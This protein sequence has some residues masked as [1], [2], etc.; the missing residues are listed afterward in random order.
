MFDDYHH[1]QARKERDVVEAALSRLRLVAPR[2]VTFSDD[3]VVAVDA[4]GGEHRLTRGGLDAPVPLDVVREALWA[5]GT[6]SFSRSRDEDSERDLAGQGTWLVD[7]LP[8][9]PVTLKPKKPDPT[10]LEQVFSADPDDLSLLRSAYRLSGLRVDVR[11]EG[12]TRARDVAVAMAAERA[13]LGLPTTLALPPARD[14]YGRLQE[15]APADGAGTWDG[16]AAGEGWSVLHRDPHSGYPYREREPETDDTVVV[17]SDRQA[18]YYASRLKEA[19]GSVPGEVALVRVFL[20]KSR[21]VA[22]IAFSPALLARLS[23]DHGFV[24]APWDVHARR[25]AKAGARVRPPNTWHPTTEAVAEAFV[26]RRAPRGMV[27]GN[28]LFFHGPVAYSRYRSSPVAAFA[29]AKDGSQVILTGREPNMRGD[30]VVSMALSD[31]HAA[32]G[33]RFAILPLEC[34]SGLVTVGDV[35]VRHFADKAG[36]SKKEGDYPATCTV[37]PAG[38]AAWVASALDEARKEVDAAHVTKFPT[39]RQ[40]QSLRAC[41]S[42]IR[43]GGKLAALFGFEPPAPEAE[44]AAFE[45]DADTVREAVRRRQSELEARKAARSP[46]VPGRSGA[47]DPGDDE[48]EETVSPAP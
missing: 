20:D 26:A 43:T 15:T 45:A 22:S 31:I 36:R 21:P 7:G 8:D 4:C 44:A 11:V 24:D 18:N 40:S 37:D 10:C 28:S 2:S 19:A 48:P 9:G 1:R 32:T 33:E 35:P 14:P 25:V 29:L 13:A 38:T 23:P 41:A 5:Y 39:W 47:G 27:S 34:L 17:T 12:E 6:R 46:G 30:A 16:P 3:A 42:I